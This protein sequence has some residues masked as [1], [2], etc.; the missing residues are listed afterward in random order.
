MRQQKGGW[1]E[2]P[3]IE[4]LTVWL[5]FGV[6]VTL[7]P[8]IFSFLQSVDSRRGFAFSSVLGDGQLLLVSV[9]IAAGAFGELVTVNMVSEKRLS[10]ILALGSSVVV[11]IVASLWFGGI[12][13]S[14][15][16]K[17]ATDP[18]AITIG[19]GFIYGWALISSAW[20]LSLSAS[21]RRPAKRD[22]TTRRSRAVAPD[23]TR[24]E[25]I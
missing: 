6:V 1:R 3:V 15:S 11:V 7:T 9:A 12:S 18:K 17:T 14:V 19:S 10:R 21:A 22:P 5:I 13:S 25:E 24:R 8:F 20:C 4:K 2:N 23:A 16:D